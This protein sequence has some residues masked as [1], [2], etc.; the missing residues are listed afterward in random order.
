MYSSTLTTKHTMFSRTRFYHSYYYYEAIQV[1]VTT[2][3][4][5]LVNGNS[6][7]DLY[8]HLYKDHFDRLNPTY[9]L[10]AWS[11]KC[12]NKDQFNLTLELFIDTKYILV[13]TTYK[14]NV[15]GSFSIIISS[16]HMVRFQQIG[17]QE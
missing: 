3:A 10:I 15:T 12:C 4:F 2:N 16:S 9:N 6:S 5:Y 8:V 7:I 14:P 17:E 13:V 11:G 1:I